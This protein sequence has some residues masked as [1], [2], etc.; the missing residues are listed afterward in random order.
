LI[1]NPLF[2][3]MPSR[4]VLA[5][6]ARTRIAPLCQAQSWKHALLVTDAYFNCQT[7]V[8]S[9]MVQALRDVGI[10]ATVYDGCLPD[11]STTLCDEATRLLAKPAGL[12]FDHVIAVGGG[13]NMDLAKALCLTLREQRPVIEF[14]GANRWP[15]KPLPMVAVP[16]TAGTGSEITPGA[17]LIVPGSTT[18]VAVMGNDLRP[19]MAII[20]P[21]LTLSCPPK[22]TADA[23]LD[24]LTH[25]I[26]SW[27]TLDSAQFDTGNDPD[28]GY[29]GRNRVTKLLARESVALCFQHLAQ[30]Y[31][32]PGDLEAR[33]GMAYASLLAAMSY[34]SSG[35]NA[36]HGIAYALAGLTH[37]SHGSTNAVL[38]PYVMDALIEERTQ[39][40]G[41]IAV[42]AG[43]PGGGDAIELARQAPVRVR[44][45]V[46]RLGIACNL[47]DF[48]VESS[49]I[50]LLIEDAL[51]V[52]RLTKAFPKASPASAYGVIVRNAYSATLSGDRD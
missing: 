27:L 20:D 21:E 34:G 41:E 37:A 35:L 25:A 10:A 8:I 13:S 1:E 16:T 26:E 38:L 36:V 33:T 11:P 15:C 40:L 23:G 48:G 42:L 44:E 5:P 46:R 39:E 45:L 43:A 3:C 18:K 30:A 6:G 17:I 28:P 50:P 7:S 12:A 51:A 24:A 32:K 29:S 49:Q 31:D 19:L 52:S 2:F 9:T 22:V 14:V 4:V 47:A